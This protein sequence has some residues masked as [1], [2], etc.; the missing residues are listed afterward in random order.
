M[1][2]ISPQQIAL[3]TKFQ[4]NYSV[5][6]ETRARQADLHP[7]KGSS[8]SV[9]YNL[10]KRKYN[11]WKDYLTVSTVTSSIN[12]S[13]NYFQH[14]SQWQRLMCNSLHSRRSGWLQ[15]SVV[16]VCMVTSPWQT[17]VIR[18]E[19]LLY[20]E[21]NIHGLEEEHGGGAEVPGN[22]PIFSCYEKAL[23]IVYR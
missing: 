21:F 15:L 16:S 14:E 1:F 5:P 19:A 13:W 11:Q 6:H 2:P 18:K 9:S 20:S 8:C 7:H 12:Y 17:S 3:T 23:V 4:P 22:P 10:R